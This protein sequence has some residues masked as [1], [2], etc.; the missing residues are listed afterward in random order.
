MRD[1]RP[2]VRRIS[3]PAGRSP[4]EPDGELAVWRRARGDRRTPSP[5]KSP[6]ALDA[7]R[8]ERH[9]PPGYVSP[10]RMP[11]AMCQM[12][13]WPASSCHRMSSCRRRRSRRCRLICQS[14]CRRSRGTASPA[15]GAAVHAPDRGLCRWC[16]ARA[17]RLPRGRRGSSAVLDGHDAAGRHVAAAVAVEVPQRQLGQPLARGVQVDPVAVAAAV[18]PPRRGR[19]RGTI[20]R[21]SAVEV[22]V[23]Q[24][25]SDSSTSTRLSHCVQPGLVSDR[26]RRVSRL[27]T[28]SI[29]PSCAKTLM[30]DVRADVGRAPQLEAVAIACRG[31]S[32][33]GCP[34][35][36]PRARSRRRSPSSRSARACRTCAC[37]VSAQQRRKFMAPVL[38]HQVPVGEIPRAVA[39]VALDGMPVLVEDVLLD[40]RIR[41]VLHL[42]A[43]TFPAARAGCGGCSCRGSARS[44]GSAR[45]CDPLPVVEDL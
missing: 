1:R 11:R 21:P 4:S 15:I 16:A 31:T 14:G 12:A 32:C 10:T 43:V 9:L 27:A 24:I 7:P 37:G 29:R 18:E 36:R 22:A 33:S 3:D 2:A 44:S 34:C 17:I 30:H 8:I 45:E 5:S 23:A 13:T 25:S 40:E 39:A 41:S 6:D 42:D 19:W 38:E 28:C 26:G 35:T 20:L